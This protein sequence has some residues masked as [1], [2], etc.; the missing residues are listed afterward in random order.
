MTMKGIGAFCLTAISV[1]PVLVY[2]KVKHWVKYAFNSEYRAERKR[3][4][5][6]V[7]EWQRRHQPKEYN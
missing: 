6:E 4:K 7:E 2:A 5:K 3:R 1:V